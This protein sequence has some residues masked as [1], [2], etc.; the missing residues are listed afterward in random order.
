[1]HTSGAG[2]STKQ[3]KSAGN[4]VDDDG[5]GAMGDGIRRGWRRRGR[6]TTTTTTM[7]TGNEVDND[8]DGATGDYNDD[9]DDGDKTTM[10]TATA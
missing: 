9:D 10:A 2:R 1:M 5:N 3:S 8:G 4:E 7:A 6:R